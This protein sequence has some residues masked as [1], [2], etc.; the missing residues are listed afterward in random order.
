MATSEP[1][2]QV[3]QLSK[4]FR[5]RGRTLRAVQ[6]ASLSLQSGKTVGVVGESG[7]GKSTLGRSILHLLTPESGRVLFGGVE[8]G[9]L[10]KEALR[11]QRREMQMIF[12]D[13]LASLNPRLTVG[14]AVEDPFIIH[15]TGGRERTALVGDLL[16]RV[17]LTRE[18][19]DAYPFELSGGQQQRVGIARAIAL[20]PKLIVADEPVSAL[21]V[22]IQIQ[23]ISLLRDLQKEMNLA[24]IF[25]SHNL[26][27][28]EYLS[29]QVLVMYLGEVVESASAQEIF[30][31]PG[32][33]YTRVLIDSILQV[34]RQGEGRRSFA[35]VKGDMP[36]PLHPPQ[37]CPFHPRCPVA[38]ARC[39]TEKPAMRRLGEEH[40]AA[41]HLA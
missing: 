7:S 26:A 3:E 15:A 1:L 39:K 35:I 40:E 9:K 4:H 19:A 21:D 10:S 31:N 24:S 11:K 16:E 25:I 29:D 14:A 18:M 5:V 17:G 8:L 30:R 34:P 12:Q 32:H 23:I 13:P 22:S 6:N 2:L 27:V 28:V 36:S 20:R 33:P 38:V 37:G 41:C